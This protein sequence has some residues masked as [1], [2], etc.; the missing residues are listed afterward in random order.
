MTVLSLQWE[1][2][3]MQRRSSHWKESMAP[4]K[5]A[6]LCN[7]RTHI[8]KFDRLYAFHFL[9]VTANGSQ[10]LHDKPSA[11]GNGYIACSVSTPR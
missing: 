7:L 4:W 1:S 9:S 8:D 2:L 10:A 11:N 6:E 5:H 3:Y